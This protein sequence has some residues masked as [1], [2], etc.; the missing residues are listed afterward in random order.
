MN[1]R[2]IQYFPNLSIIMSILKKVNSFL[3][4][5]C[6]IN[7]FF[8]LFINLACLSV[9]VLVCLFVSNKRQNGWT[10]WA[11]IVCWTSND[12]RKVYEWS[13][14]KKFVFEF[15]YFC[16]TLKMREKILRN[17][18]TYC[19]VLVLFFT[20]RGCSQI[21]P[22]LKDEIKDGRE[23]PWNPSNKYLPM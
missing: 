5:F 8:H 9:W 13:K 7:I 11:Q 1:S 4:V 17:P 2:Y 16:K 6:S 22:Q 3:N 19:F 18:Q 20:N 21:K 12:H 23:A 10:E 15:F 14:F